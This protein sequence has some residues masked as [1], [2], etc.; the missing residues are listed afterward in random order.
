MFKRQ[1]LLALHVLSLHKR[2]PAVE[3]R[4]SPSMMLFKPEFKLK[5][6]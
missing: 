4:K 3:A 5:K 6:K 2:A 1:R